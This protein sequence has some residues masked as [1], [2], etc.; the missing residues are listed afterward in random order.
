MRAWEGQRFWNGSAT[1]Q[2]LQERCRS[3]ESLYHIIRT[4]G[5]QTP[6][7]V[8]YGTTVIAKTCLPQEIK[9]SIG[10]DGTFLLQTE[11]HRLSIALLLSIQLIP[12]QVAVRHID[13]Q[14]L[15]DRV[16]SARQSAGI[17]A[18]ESSVLFHPDISYLLQ[19][20]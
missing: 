4:G 6:P 15:R 2:Q 9:V 7:G 8:V 16:L 18:A 14:E 17:G 12:V 5:F 1:I 13:W 19:V 3:I 20:R 10:R 11:R